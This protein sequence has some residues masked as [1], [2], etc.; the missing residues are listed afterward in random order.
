[1]KLIIMGNH[2]GVRKIFQ[3]FSGL[4]GIT[5][6]ESASGDEAELRT[7]KIKSNWVTMPATT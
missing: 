2:A 6:C 3:T 7:L 1:M 4:P 5:F